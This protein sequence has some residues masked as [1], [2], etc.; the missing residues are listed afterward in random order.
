M[1]VKPITVLYMFTMLRMLYY[2]FGYQQYG[3]INIYKITY[4]IIILLIT[5]LSLQR[6]CFTGWIYIYPYRYPK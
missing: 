6:D 3:I 1:I 2:Q 4:L 5:K